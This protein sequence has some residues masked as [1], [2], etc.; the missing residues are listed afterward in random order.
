MKRTIIIFLMIALLACVSIYEE[1]LVNQ[2]TNNLSFY[3]E[4]LSI[5]INDN[6]ADINKE[7]VLDKYTSLDDF[8][9]Q[10]KIKLCMFTN[11]DKIRFVDESL[12]KIHDGIVKSDVDLVKENISSIRSFNEYASYILG[13]N[14]NNLF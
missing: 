10:Q 12:Q 4:E 9:E 13:F 14:I 5:S 3:T 11:Y 6:N 2:T 1:M 7:I 8:W